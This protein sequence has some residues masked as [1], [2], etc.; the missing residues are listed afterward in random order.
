MSIQQSPRPA[1]PSS[2][3]P[4]L[5]AV[6][7]ALVTSVLF[8]AALWLIEGINVLDHNGLDSWGIVPRNTDGL[9]GIAFAPLLHAGWGHLMAN[10]VP[11][12]VLGF[13][14]LVAGAARFLSAT[15]LVWV[16]SGIGVWL[17]GGSNTVVIG[18]SGVLFGWMT[19]VVLRG[20]L[21]RDL[22]WSLVG[23]VL[24]VLYGGM[25]WGVIPGQVGISWQAHLW[26]AI[27]GVL[28]AVLLRRR[29]PV[30]RASALPDIR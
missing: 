6:R 1:T 9:R 18:L 7:T 21:S 25:L 5:V 13:V 3:R 20:F 2:G 11:A 27:G 24:L 28:A 29:R 4:G 15:V 16:V 19:Y 23:V 8:V 10:S 17:T 30:E 14:G 22:L 26:G 12:L